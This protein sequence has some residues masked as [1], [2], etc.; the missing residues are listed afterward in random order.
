MKP[1]SEETKNQFL[2]NNKDVLR[3]Y[4]EAPEDEENVVPQKTMRK[5][6]A[7]SPRTAGEVKTIL[8]NVDQIVAVEVFENICRVYTAIVKPGPHGP[9]PLSYDVWTSDF[10][11][12]FASVFAD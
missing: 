7:L 11:K 6:I 2:I 10:E 9:M 8:I 4:E 1:K 5:F 12:E 3:N